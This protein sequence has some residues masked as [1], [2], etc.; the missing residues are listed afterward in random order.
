MLILRLTQ[1]SHSF[2]LYISVTPTF[3]TL[4]L[5]IFQLRWQSFPLPPKNTLLYIKIPYKTNE[6]KVNGEGGR[7]SEA[8][9]EL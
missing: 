4:V 3:S 6:K 7:E 9:P 8:E 1:W 5:S 2:H